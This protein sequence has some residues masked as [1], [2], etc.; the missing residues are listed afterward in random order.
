MPRIDEIK[1]LKALL[2]SCNRKKASPGN[3]FAKMKIKERLA[4]FKETA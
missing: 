2:R 3:G 4:E 1:H